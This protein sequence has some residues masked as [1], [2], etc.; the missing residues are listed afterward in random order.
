VVARMG[1]C[2][3]EYEDVPGVAMCSDTTKPAPKCEDAL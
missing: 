1:R 2:N 3:P